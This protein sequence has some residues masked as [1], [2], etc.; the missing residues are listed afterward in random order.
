MA[1]PM[2]EVITDCREILRSLKKMKKS[3][4]LPL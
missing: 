1:A 2:I 4:G 3:L